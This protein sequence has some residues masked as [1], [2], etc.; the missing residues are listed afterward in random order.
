LSS[1]SKGLVL[2]AV[3]LAIGAGLVVWKSKVGGHAEDSFNRITKEEMEVLLKDANPMLLKR[4][5]EDPELKKQQVDNLKQLLALA[6][7]A[8]KEGLTREPDIRQELENVKAEITAVNYDKDINKD[9]GPMPPFGFI[10]E[11]RTKEY[12]AGGHDAEFQKFIDTK[13]KILKESN[14]EMKD[15]EISDEEMTQAKDFFAKIQI[16]NKEYNDKVAAGAIPK[17]FQDKVALQIKLQQASFLAQNYSKKLAE[18][19]KVTDEDIAKYITEHPELDPKAKRDQAEEILKRA[20]GGEDFAKLANEFSTD[21]GN[22]SPKGELQG[23]LYKDVTKG[24]MMPEFEAAALA[25]E[26]GK[27]S[28]NLVETPYGFHIIKLDRKGESKDAK[29]QTSETYDVR[30]ILIST[31][32]KDPENPMSREMPVKEFV[33][34]KLEGEKEKAVMDDIVAKNNVEVAEDFVIPE[35]SEEQMK[36]MQEK[37][38][39]QQMQMQGM[40]QGGPEGA[41]NGANPKSPNGKPVPPPPAGAKPA[42][43]P[44]TK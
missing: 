31:G 35:V 34:S 30:H 40:P 14:P 41:P 4:L 22:K 13:I 21:P 15:R 17:E 36:Q 44:P 6:S 43:K 10:D 3:I 28:P 19:T 32:V 12:W 2:V 42:P 25:L 11:A 18:K 9:K 29:G 26:P 23:G 33:K 39:Q 7:Q 8:Q 27:I 16:Y 37:M 1:L 24:K 38:M 20:Q 5:K